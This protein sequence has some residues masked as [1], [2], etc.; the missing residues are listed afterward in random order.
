MIAYKSEEEYDLER[1]VVATRNFHLA[2]FFLTGTIMHQQREDIT[3]ARIQKEVTWGHGTG[4]QS[5]GIVKGPESHA[6]W[7]SVVM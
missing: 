5:S 4:T 3:Q 2:V 6:F 1:E 7:A